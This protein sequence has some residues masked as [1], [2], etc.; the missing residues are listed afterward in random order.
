[1]TPLQIPARAGSSRLSD[2]R[3]VSPRA[4]TWD[5]LPDTEDEHTR[6]PRSERGRRR[7]E[8]G[9][10]SGQRRS[11]RTDRSAKTSRAARRE[12]HWKE[13][14]DRVAQAVER[15]V[16]HDAHAEHE[17]IMLDEEHRKRFHSHQAVFML[18]ALL[19]LL[20]VA[21]MSVFTGALILAFPIPGMMYGAICA[22]A[23]W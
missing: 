4:T 1:M 23:A 10:Q 6:L 15:A 14:D 18:G 19:L 17:A 2:R 22:A 20:P 5:D 21:S 3:R 9:A 16:F 12:P 13:D 7:K 11:G 8:R